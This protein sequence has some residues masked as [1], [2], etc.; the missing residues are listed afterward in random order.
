M[1]ARPSE[2]SPVTIC[3][4]RYASRLEFRPNWRARWL[5]SSWCRASSVPPADQVC[6]G[7]VRPRWAQPRTVSQRGVL[8]R[9]GTAPGAISH[10]DPM[11]AHAM[12]CSARDTSQ[13]SSLH[14]TPGAV[15]AFTQRGQKKSDGT[16]CR[17]DYD[18]SSYRVSG[19]GKASLGLEL[20]ASATTC[21]PPWPRAALRGH[22]EAC[23]VGVSRRDMQPP[24]T[25]D[26]VG[27]MC[28]P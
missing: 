20:S 9:L 14:H 27:C 24:G 19:H 7:R 17:Y 4:L 1:Q 22:L 11:A 6:V 5:A 8:A 25:D 3:S 16:S 15:T 2:R 18:T 26:Q 21:S 12:S 28:G 10:R 23:S 13:A